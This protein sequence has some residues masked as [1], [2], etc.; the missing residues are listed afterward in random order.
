MTPF[1]PVWVEIRTVSTTDS[2]V[3]FSKDSWQMMMIWK[4]PVKM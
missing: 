4:C 2:T 1:E 3:C